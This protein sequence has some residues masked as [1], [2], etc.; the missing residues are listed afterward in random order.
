M[1][2]MSNGCFGRTLALYVGKQ[3][4]LFTKLHFQIVIGVRWPAALGSGPRWWPGDCREIWVRLGAWLVSSHPQG[5][6]VC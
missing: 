3:Q 5:V 2:R 4:W 6:I 1:D